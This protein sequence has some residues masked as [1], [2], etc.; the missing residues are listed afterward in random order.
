[1]THRWVTHRSRERPSETYEGCSRCGI[2]R[3]RTTEL[4]PCQP[5]R[6]TVLDLLVVATLGLVL[7]VLFMAFLLGVGQLT[8]S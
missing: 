1:M 8:S 3:D 6:P 4:E 2:T 5:P 7:F